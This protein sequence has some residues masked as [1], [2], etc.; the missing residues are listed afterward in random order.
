MTVLSALSEPSGNAIDWWF[1]YKLPQG[2]SINGSVKTKGREYLYFDP[3]GD[4]A[5]AIT[6]QPIN[7]PG[8]ALIQTLDQLNENNRSTNRSLGW[9][10]YNDEKPDGTSD[11][12]S[13]GHSKGV[14][15]FDQQTARSGWFIRGLVFH[16]FTMPTRQA[17]NT[18]RHFCALH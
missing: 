7:V 12:S 3:T 17:F 15:V 1:A 6:G 11:S 13:I 2:A 5:L 9:I 18:D 4:K 14:L 10:L 16:L 8:S